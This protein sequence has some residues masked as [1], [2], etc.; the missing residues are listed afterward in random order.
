MNRYKD[1][2]EKKGTQWFAFYLKPR[3]EK[4]VAERLAEPYTIFCPLKEERVKWSDRWKTVT[5][6]VIPGYL[7][8]RVTEAQRRKLLTD[9][10]VLRTVCHRGKPAPIRND[11]IDVMKKV[12]SHPD[13][14]E[15]ELEPIS[16]GDRVT[17][18]GGE[19]MN[20]NG[21]VVT[22]FGNRAKIKIDSLRCNMAFTVNRA[23]LKTV[24]TE[25]QV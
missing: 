2:A 6:P 17:V 18:T 21:A 4:K 11:E 14:V 25:S 1:I 7:F 22:V 13:I 10:S 3:H 9:P 5:K 23:L 12:V 16:P 19:L 8:A 20:L 24:G 15:M